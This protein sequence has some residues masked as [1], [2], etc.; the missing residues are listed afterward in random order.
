MSFSIFNPDETNNLNQINDMTFNNLNLTMNSE[1][2]ERESIRHH[3]KEISFE[4]KHTKMLN[5][6][7]NFDKK[8]IEIS[9][10]LGEI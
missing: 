6:M 5:K 7:N 9:N 1:M 10:M 2:K 4:D 8:Y 3:H